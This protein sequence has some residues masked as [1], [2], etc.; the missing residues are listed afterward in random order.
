V[1][2]YLYLPFFPSFIHSFI[3][4]LIHSFFLLLLFLLFFRLLVRSVIHSSLFDSFVPLF[5]TCF[6]SFH[7]YRNALKCAVVAFGILFVP[8]LLSFATTLNEFF[9]YMYIVT[10]ASKVCRESFYLI[11]ITTS[12]S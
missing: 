10:D 5:T 12:S 1:D 11:N 2:L 6:D 7:P 4:S 8:F 3:H 9:V